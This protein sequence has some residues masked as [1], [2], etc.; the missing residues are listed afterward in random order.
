M[1]KAGKILAVLLAA[2]AVMIISARLLDGSLFVGHLQSLAL[3]LGLPLCLLGAGFL[4]WTSPTSAMLVLA[5]VILPFCSIVI[6]ASIL[7]IWP[8]FPLLPKETALSCLFAGNAVA[9]VI[10]LLAWIAERNGTHNK[11]AQDIV[12]AAPNPD[13]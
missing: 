10:S 6:H 5:T 4:Q 8:L 7:P 12:A 3:Y 13:H 11:T 9:V 2:N 1:E